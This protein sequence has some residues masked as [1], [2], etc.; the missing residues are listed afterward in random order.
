MPSEEVVVE[1][2]DDLVH[3][4]AGTFSFSEVQS[5]EEVEAEQVESEPTS[6][7]GL[8]I[9]LDKVQYFDLED[10]GTGNAD[11]KNPTDLLGAL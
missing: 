6:I 2:T 7:D 9:C 5:Q 1:S 4:I 8:L 11:L 10:Q 3:H